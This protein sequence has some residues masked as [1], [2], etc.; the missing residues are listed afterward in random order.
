MGKGQKERMN[1]P[2][3]NAGSVSKAANIKTGK[4]HTFYHK[5]ENRQTNKKRQ[6]DFLP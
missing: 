6:T 5:F 1:P 4:M 3:A 2:K